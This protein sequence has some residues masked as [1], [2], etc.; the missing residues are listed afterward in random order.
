[1]AA[2]ITLS[3]LRHAARGFYY[4]TALYSLYCACIQTIA[5]LPI[6]SE[7]VNYVADKLVDVAADIW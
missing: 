7:G 6:L 4:S 2:A 5:D 1:M 3:T